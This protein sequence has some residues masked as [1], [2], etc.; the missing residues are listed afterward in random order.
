MMLTDN[1]YFVSVMDVTLAITV[2]VLARSFLGNVLSKRLELMRWG[3]KHT[4][5]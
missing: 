3:S 4:E 5:W 2:I 1:F